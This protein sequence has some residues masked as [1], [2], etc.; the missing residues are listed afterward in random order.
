MKECHTYIISISAAHLA[1]GSSK[2]E[3]GLIIIR[4]ISVQMKNGYNEKKR[5]RTDFAR[6]ASTSCPLS[7]IAEM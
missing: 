7:N 6:S 1:F 5:K 3:S 2:L 4:Y